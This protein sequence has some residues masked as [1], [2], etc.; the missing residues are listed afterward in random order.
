MS[1]LAIDFGG[2]RTRAAWYSASL[3]MIARS[4]T[5]SLVDQPAAH[6]LNRIIETA[7]AVVPDGVQPTAIGISAPGPLD[8]E[9]GIIFHART[10]PRWRMV[11]LKGILSLAFGGVPTYMQNDANLAA[12]AEAECGAA[13]G[14]DP[15]LYLTLS[16]G[17]GGGAVIGGRL[18]TGARGL[19]IEPGHIQCTLPDGRILRLEELASGSGIA[20][21]AFERLKQDDKPS[22]LRTV[23]GKVSAKSV[24]EAAEQGDALALS[25]IKEAGYWLGLGLVDLLHL[26]NPQAVVIGG[27]VA[28]LGDLLFD[29]ARK[30]IRERILHPDFYTEDLI[31]PAQLGD[32]VCLV[33]A[34][35]L[36]A[37]GGRL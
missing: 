25:I 37:R 11:P 24:G 9:Q 17:I 10:L 6:V 33:G 7:R 5:P 14:C 21:Q 35:L 20:W 34:A 29:P 23:T 16:T 1:I 31:R 2:T 27:S 22:I 3:E 32:D 19:A 13:R 28:Q 12:V 15:V 4:E 36:A 8:A 26:F 18:F 30:V